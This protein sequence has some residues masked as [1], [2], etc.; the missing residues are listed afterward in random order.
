[1]AESNRLRLQT[2]ILFLD[3]DGVLNSLR[4]FEARQNRGLRTAGRLDHD[5]VE[6]VDELVERLGLQ[7]VISSAWRHDANDAKMRL[8]PILRRHGFAGPFHRD[9]VTPYL[10]QQA[11]GVEIQKWMT[12]HRIEPWQILILD[13]SA[14]MVHLSE[15]LVRTQFEDGLQR[16]HIE[17][18]VEL[19]A[20]QVVNN[21][22]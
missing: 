16:R 12:K 9:P 4:W 6:L 13:D 11:R 1:M 3:F 8:H 10:P 22:R 14:D 7:V 17:Q 21:A 19:F 18:A 5:A 20:Q 2:R 15:R